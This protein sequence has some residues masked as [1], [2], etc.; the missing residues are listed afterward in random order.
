MTK[1]KHTITGPNA[2]M[3]TAMY[4]PDANGYP[5]YLRKPTKAELELWE[6]LQRARDIIQDTNQWLTKGDKPLEELLHEMGQF[7]NDVPPRI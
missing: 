4:V 5:E 7:L 1:L 2:S 3:P 6:A